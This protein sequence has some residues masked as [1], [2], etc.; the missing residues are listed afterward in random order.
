WEKLTINRRCR[1]EH[2]M[3]CTRKRDSRYSFST[4][5]CQFSILLSTQK[6]CAPTVSD[7]RALV[8]ERELRRD[9]TAAK[10]ETA[11]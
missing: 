4:V 6:G 5:N 2:S 3:A 9:G 8:T 7:G 10:G 1:A 11:A